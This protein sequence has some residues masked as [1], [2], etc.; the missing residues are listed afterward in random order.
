MKSCGFYTSG[1]YFLQVEAV[2][3]AAP[4][5]FGG[6]ILYACSIYVKVNGTPIS[7]TNG[8][9][10]Q[11]APWSYW[12]DFFKV[13]NR[14]YVEIT[15]VYETLN[16][17]LGNPL[18]SNTLVVYDGIRMGGGSPPDEYAIFENNDA[19]NPITLSLEQN[20]PN[21]FNPST[22]I[23]YTLTENSTIKLAIFN[24]LGEEIL[25]LEDGFKSAGTYEIKFDASKLPSGVY[26]Y[27]LIS[28]KQFDI[29][30]FMIKK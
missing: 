7:S 26:F 25:I 10:G 1:S 4:C 21:P 3:V 9:L 24:S 15:M 11:D 2:N 14:D 23:R 16:Y 12:S 18:F 29:K 20:Y 6:M 30:K 22:T 28:E 8:W 27:K 13:Q 17:C 19:D 5:E